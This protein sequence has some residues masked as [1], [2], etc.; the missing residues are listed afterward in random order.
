MTRCTVCAAVEGSDRAYS[1]T[2]RLQGLLGGLITE[3]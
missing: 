3:T 2:W 1:H